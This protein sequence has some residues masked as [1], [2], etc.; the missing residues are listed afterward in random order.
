MAQWKIQTDAKESVTGGEAWV[1]AGVRP[2]QDG[3]FSLR[4]ARKAEKQPREDGRLPYG[5]W[6]HYLWI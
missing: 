1:T 3:P 4:E 2:Q 6:F 5:L